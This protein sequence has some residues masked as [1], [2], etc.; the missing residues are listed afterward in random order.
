MSIFNWFRRKKPV[1]PGW[2]IVPPGHEVKIVYPG[3]QAYFGKMQSGAWIADFGSGRKYE[4][5]FEATE[6]ALRQDPTL[7]IIWIIQANALEGWTSEAATLAAWLQHFHLV[8]RTRGADVETGDVAVVPRS[9]A[10][11]RAVMLLLRSLGVGVHLP[12][13]DGAAYVEV[14]RPDGIVVGMPGPAFEDAPDRFLRQLNLEQDAVKDCPDAATKLREIARRELD[15]VAEVMRN[16]S[17][18][19]V[20]QTLGNKALSVL[21]LPELVT[22]AADKPTVEYREAF[23]GALLP[24]K[25]GAPWPIPPDELIRTGKYQT[26]SGDQFGIPVTLGPDGLPWYLVIADTAALAAG[27]P[28]ETYGEVYTRVVLEMALDRGYGGVIVQ[29]KADGKDSWVGVPKEHVADIL[30]GRYAPLFTR[31]WNR[32][33]DR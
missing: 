7:N 23:Y 17:F 33:D 27:H 9:G 14:H 3:S 24:C 12:G 1:R 32:G 13:P 22:L 15:F 26:K 25:V 21:S 11:A 28:G 20:R 8:R 10:N 30:D 29:N 31:G 19:M 5:L 16:M 4:Q 18:D 2:G 6:R